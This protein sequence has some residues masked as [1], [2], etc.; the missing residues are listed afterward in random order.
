MKY[1]INKK[2][3]VLIL[4]LISLSIGNIRKNKLI[5]FWQYQYSYNQDTLLKIP[6]FNKMPFSE[7]TI[8]LDKNEYNK[9]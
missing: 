3:M 7:F 4:G 1:S 5:A 2:I 6:S 9:I 8:Y